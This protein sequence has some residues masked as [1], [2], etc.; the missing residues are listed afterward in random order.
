MTKP[1]ST[2]GVEKATNKN[3]DER[4]KVLDDIVARDLT[5]KEMIVLTMLLRRDWNSPISSRLY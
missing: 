4:V 5:Y 2:D 1:I 3:W